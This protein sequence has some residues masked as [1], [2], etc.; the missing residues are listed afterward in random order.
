MFMDSCFVFPAS[1]WSC[2]SRSRWLG[3]TQ[4]VGQWRYILAMP[5]PDAQKELDR[6]EQELNA[7]ASPPVEEGR[8]ARVNRKQPHLDAV[9]LGVVAL[10]AASFLLS[11]IKTLN[12][13]TIDSLSSGYLCGSIG[14]EVGYVI[15][16]SH[17]I[18]R[19]SPRGKSGWWTGMRRCRP[20]Q[21]RCTNISSQFEVVSF[22]GWS[23]DITEVHS[24]QSTTI[25][26]GEASSVVALVISA[27]SNL[28]WSIRVALPSLV[29]SN[30]L[31]SFPVSTVFN[32]LIV[33]LTV[34][35][36]VTSCE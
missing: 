19:R 13:E 4:I 25:A 12:N 14:L 10:L 18:L 20:N 30:L 36:S 26:S 9:L 8:I 2:S 31:S 15:G 32:S 34:S 21:I 28:P 35:F 3:L 22:L 6:I 24:D 27:I 17:P 16:R 1:F 23:P 11:I 5:W 33:P 7:K 29:S